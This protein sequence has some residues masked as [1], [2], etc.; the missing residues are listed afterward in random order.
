MTAEGGRIRARPMGKQ[1]DV[2]RARAPS[3]EAVLVDADGNRT[4]DPSEAVGGEI[5]ELDGAARPTRRTW[6]FAS[7]VEVKWLPVGEAAF[8]LWV[9][10]L[11]IGVWLGI[12]FALGL[13]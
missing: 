6:F 13:I 2:D 7:E 10:A 11:L 12:G 9:L 1:D 5:V 4:E 8:L 3:Y